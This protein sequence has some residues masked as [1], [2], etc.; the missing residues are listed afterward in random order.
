[1]SARGFPAA[2]ARGIKPSAQP[3]AAMTAYA[4][5]ERAEVGIVTLNRFCFC[6][7]FAPLVFVCDKQWLELFAAKQHDIEVVRQ[8]VG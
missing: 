2:G 1:V 4:K 6:K 8:A 5:F 3:S 7:N